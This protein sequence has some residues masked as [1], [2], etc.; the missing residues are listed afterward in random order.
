M[1]WGEPG[2]RESVMRPTRR[3]AMSTLIGRAL[4]QSRNHGRGLRK[5]EIQGWG[6]WSVVQ[7]VIGKGFREI[8]KWVDSLGATLNSET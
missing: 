7:K 4:G 3:V 6:Q 1:G 5:A 8:R 2:G